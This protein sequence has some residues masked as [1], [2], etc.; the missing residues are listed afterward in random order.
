M[1]RWANRHYDSYLDQCR[2]F[3]IRMCQ[4]LF[5]HQSNLV[6]HSFRTLN[7]SNPQ[8]F[9][10]WIIF[11]IDP[12]TTE[13]NPSQWSSTS[14]TQVRQIHRAVILN[15]ISVLLSCISVFLNG[16]SVFLNCITVFLYLSSVFLR[17]FA[18][19][20]QMRQ[21]HLEGAVWT[22]PFLFSSSSLSSSPPSSPSP[23][24]QSLPSSA[25]C[26]LAVW[27]SKESEELEFWCKDDHLLFCI[28]LI[29]SMSEE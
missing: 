6:S 24:I 12:T 28:S 2:F 17:R 29:W 15:C 26:E 14:Q 20:L 16:I 9:K 18:I 7:K 5:Y 21:L 25:I 23:S 4:H 22:F 10:L 1:L 19:P 3:L 13:S 8:Q 27:Q 11:R